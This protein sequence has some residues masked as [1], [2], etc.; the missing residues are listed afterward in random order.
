M[1]APPLQPN[2]PATD[3]KALAEL[4]DVPEGTLKRWAQSDN[5]PRRHTTTHRGRRTEYS[6]DAACASHAK[7]RGAV[8]PPGE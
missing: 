4:L 8:R 3:V 6:I 2:D 7:R 5:W 1:T